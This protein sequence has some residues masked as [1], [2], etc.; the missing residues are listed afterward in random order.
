MIHPTPIIQHTSWS[1]F[2]KNFLKQWK[3]E[4]VYKEHY[5]LH[6]CKVILVGWPLVVLWCTTLV[7]LWCTTTRFSPNTRPGWI[8]LDQVVMVRL[9][10][11]V[12]A[13]SPGQWVFDFKHLNFTC[14][15]HIWP[16][17]LTLTPWYLIRATVKSCI[18]LLFCF[19]WII[20][21]QFCTVMGWYNFYHHKDIRIHS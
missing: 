8:R 20:W 6:A 13:V 21:V 1:Y 10:R 7:V 5:S 17:H 15:L 9:L 12:L 11:C 3:N 14:D 2:I 4:F 18:L 19:V 16:S